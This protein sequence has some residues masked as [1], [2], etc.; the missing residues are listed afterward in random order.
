[1]IGMPYGFP[2]AHPNCRLT[3]KATN[4]APFE[5]LASNSTISRN[6][7]HLHFRTELIVILKRIIIEK[8]LIVAVAV[9]HYNN[10]SSAKK[11][12]GVVEVVAGSWC[13][14][15]FMIDRACCLKCM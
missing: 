6:I 15:I 2:S 9:V 13:D 14:I 12:V 4:S 7:L 8:V 10:S 3:R 1:M 5:I 11:V